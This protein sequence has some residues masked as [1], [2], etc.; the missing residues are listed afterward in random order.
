MSP[1]TRTRL[2]WIFYLWISAEMIGFASTQILPWMYQ[3]PE[4]L[5]RF[6]LD[7]ARQQQDFERYR[8]TSMS[9]MAGFKPPSNFDD[10]ETNCLKQKV[11]AHYDSEGVRSYRGFLPMEAEVILAGDSYT[12]GHEIN[13]DD[14][15]AAQLLRNHNTMAA[16]TA[17][18]AYCPLQ[19]FLRAK[20]L[21]DK[22]PR[23][24]FVILGIQYD[25]IR[26]LTNGYRPI[27]MQAQPNYFAF[28]PYILD[29]EIHMMDPSIF[30]S[31]EHFVAATQKAVTDDYWA[32]PMP[33][34][35][36]SYH[37]VQALF[38]P[39]FKQKFWN[40]FLEKKY[41]Y[42]RSS[43]DDAELG[44]NLFTV[45]V[46]FSEWARGENLRPIVFFMPAG[47]RNPLQDANGWIERY[48]DRLPPYLL[49]RNMTR[50]NIPVEKY[51][52]IDNYCHPSPEGAG[53]IA[54]QFK[55][56]IEESRR[57]PL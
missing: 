45:I 43:F 51:T 31:Y 42:Y 44:E 7:D 52:L 22:F 16:N 13:D 32:L 15:I 41:G 9:P 47:M 20:E 46:K 24:K 17:Y 55:Q 54:R 26:R 30:A 40:Y 2:Q 12:F 39:T 3:K 23:A 50:L 4:Y 36:Y 10:N 29:R 48:K 57:K 53:E 5:P 33:G 21:R 27:I 8:R 25:G 19:S 14:T 1:K 6:S 35:P 18:K 34:F 37:F 49:L 28:K 11:T 56:A 38:T